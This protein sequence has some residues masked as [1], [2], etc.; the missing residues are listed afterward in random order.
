MEKRLKN[1]KVIKKEDVNYPEHL[2]KIKKPPEQLY[3][4]GDETLLNKQS[5]AIIGS[6]DCT[7]YGYEQAER[8][9]KELA[10]ENICIVSGMAIGI[11]SASHIGAKSELGKT[12]AVLGSGFNHI[13]PEEN[14]ELFLHFFNLMI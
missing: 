5:I 8:F 7:Q 6:R 13:F 4:L 11:D 9:A 1:I 14:E 3:V 12:I 10:R 2:L